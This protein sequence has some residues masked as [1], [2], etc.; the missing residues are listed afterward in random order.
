MILNLFLPEKI[1]GIR[2]ITKR[3]IALG[4]HGD[5]VSL[6]K[7]TA[8]HKQTIIENISQEQIKAGSTETFPKRA[9]NAIKKIM[10][11]VTQYDQLR[12]AIP[13]SKAVFKSMF[14]PLTDID[15]IRLVVE[16]EVEDQ[17]PFSIDNA[18]IDFVITKKSD[19]GCQIMVSAVR[20]EELKETIHI[21]ELANIFPTQITI[22]LFALYDL[23]RLIPTYNNI[24]DGSA[25]IDIGHNFTRIAFLQD[26]QLSL[27]RNLP[28]GLSLIAEQVSKDCNL[29]YNIVLEQ[30]KT[31]FNKPDKEYPDSLNPDSLNPDSLNPDSLEKHLISYLNDIQF[32]L[33]S[34]SLKLAF[35]KEIKK[36]FFTNLSSQSNITKVASKILQTPCEVFDVTKA[37]EIPDIKNNTKKMVK[38]WN[39]YTRALSIALASK[40]AHEPNFMQKSFSYHDIP[41]I[42]NQIK[43]AILILIITIS[44]ISMIGY[45]HIKNLS[46]SI[47]ERELTETNSLKKLLQKGRSSTKDPVTL[48]YIDRALKS[49]NFAALIRQ[50]DNLVKTE[51]R[52]WLDLDKLKIN[53]LE[54]MLAITNL[55]DI[56]KFN[57]TIE[58]ITIT[59]N[60]DGKS[61]INV[62]GIFQSK[63]EGKDWEKFVQ[64]KQKLKKDSKGL[65]LDLISVDDST[66]DDDV[67][68]KFVLKFKYRE[69]SV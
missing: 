20:K 34:F 44:S 18:I 42:R 41:M 37:F 55:I 11:D 28:K 35:Y 53:P 56:K 2:L 29:E 62:S 68:V 60:K 48:N 47:N 16:N 63:E 25:I 5:R 12:I 36:I 59:P 66:R 14:I 46:L 40:Q 67:G 52:A 69:K 17:L 21:Y 13:A 50:T 45:F 64:F 32:T 54:N 61:S 26:G 22:D 65:K 43:S 6:V 8:K 23:Y 39:D 4:L 3:I 1:Q 57:V 24:T 38:N 51:G 49:A 31:G 15:K 58:E 7:I 9:S 10:Q 30:I 19:D 27:I 33:N